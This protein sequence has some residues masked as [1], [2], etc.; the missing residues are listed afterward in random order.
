MAADLNKRAD[1]RANHRMQERVALDG[2]SQNL[3]AKHDFVTKLGAHHTAMR[4]LAHSRGHL[5]KTLKILFS[6]KGRTRLSHSL[7]I[8]RI[9]RPPY[10]TPRKDGTGITGSDP[11]GIRSRACI[12][13]GREA[14]SS[15]VDLINGNILRK[16]GIH[17]PQPS[18]PRQRELR[19]H[20]G[21]TDILRHCVH[22]GIGA[23]R[24]RQIDG[25]PQKRLD[26]TAQLAGNR[27]LTRLLGKTTVRRTV[28]GDP[29]NQRSF[30]LI[31]GVDSRYLNHGSLPRSRAT[32]RKTST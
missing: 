17:S 1:D 2:K 24:T 29:Q 20:H 13:A 26:R 10:G 27:S 31:R 28:I 14:L 32:R 8:K 3:F 15:R 11:I 5:A 7:N 6:H 21:E 25:T 9:P 22:S 16:Q 23:A 30:K 19:R 4:R 12:K 18:A